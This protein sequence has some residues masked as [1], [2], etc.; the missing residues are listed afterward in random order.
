MAIP[1]KVFPVRPIVTYR[2]NRTQPTDEG[3]SS[4]TALT[5]RKQ[6]KSLRC[7]TFTAGPYMSPEWFHPFWSHGE[8]NVQ[9]IACVPWAS[10]NPFTR[11]SITSS[12]PDLTGPLQMYFFFSLGSLFI[13][14][15]TFKCM[16]LCI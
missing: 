6:P 8:H 4:T 15:T 16:H 12:S 10:H 2:K 13:L 14:L 3:L 11:C 9:S 5:V 1:G 7:S